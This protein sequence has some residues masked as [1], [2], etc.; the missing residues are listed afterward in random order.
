[1][2]NC[3]LLATTNIYAQKSFITPDT[4]E[5]FI[6]EDSIS[7]R[8]IRR[9]KHLE[10]LMNE[11]KFYSHADRP[12]R[13][14]ALYALGLPGLGQ[15]YNRKFWKVPIVYGAM[16]TTMFFAV[17][18][19]KN[20]RRYNAALFNDLRDLPHEFSGVL[21]TEQI[22]RSRNFY[23]KNMELS[24]LLTGLFWGLSIVDATVDAHLFKFDISDDLTFQWAPNLLTGNNKL[25]PGIHLSLT[26]N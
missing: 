23:K 15:V 7:K 1:M 20:M 9:A 22:T 12:G 24:F 8:E 14:A 21:T 25:M 6:E 17:T 16:G 13:K 4:S 3:F 18:N 10:R 19:A 26:F 2:F 5:V 11:P